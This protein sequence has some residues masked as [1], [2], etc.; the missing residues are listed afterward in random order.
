MNASIVFVK[1]KPAEASRPSKSQPRNKQKG[2]AMEMTKLLSQAQRQLTEVTGFKPVAVT[3]AVKDAKGWHVGI[4]LIEMARIPSA[5][6]LLGYY[7]VLLD[8][9]AN[10]L[11]FERKRTRVR[12]QPMEEEIA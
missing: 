9:D 10:M 5:S 7:E 11:Q 8:K 6:D 3:H 12:G 4:E 2:P 1:P